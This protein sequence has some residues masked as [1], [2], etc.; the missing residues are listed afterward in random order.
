[1]WGVWET[2]E[3]DT[4]FS[5]VDLRERDHLEGLDIDGRAILKLIF[6]KRDREAPKGLM[7]PRIGTGGGR[8]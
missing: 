3:L 5:C 4:G 2:R 8:L 1:V 6:K 7:W